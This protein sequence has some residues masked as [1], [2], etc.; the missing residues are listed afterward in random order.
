MTDKLLQ[1]VNT[2]EWREIFWTR[3]KDFRDLKGQY[4]LV[5]LEN[6]IGHQ[7]QWHSRCLCLVVKG[8]MEPNTKDDRDVGKIAATLEKETGISRYHPLQYY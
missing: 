8:M 2:L 4:T 7:G 3:R 5:A 1:Q 6:M